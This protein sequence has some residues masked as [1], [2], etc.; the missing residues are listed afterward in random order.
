MMAYPPRIAMLSLRP[1]LTSY[2]VL[3]ENRRHCTTVSE[4]L[5]GNSESL[6]TTSS[7]DSDATATLSP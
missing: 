3:N 2:L 1:I 7:I 5:H 6:L 4:S